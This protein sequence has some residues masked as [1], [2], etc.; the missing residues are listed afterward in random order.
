M[1]IRASLSLAIGLACAIVACYAAGSTAP[2]GTL[3][4]VSGDGQKAVM[5]EGAAAFAPL[6]VQARDAGQKPIAGAAVRF[7]CRAPHLGCYLGSL[8]G[9]PSAVVISRSDGRASLGS[10]AYGV[11]VYWTRQFYTR[12]NP[13]PVVVDASVDGRGGHVSFHLVPINPYSLP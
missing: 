8:G 10:G 7:V 5:K 1:S 12:K 4:I 13:E 11:Y 6:V 2:V 3:A 9:G